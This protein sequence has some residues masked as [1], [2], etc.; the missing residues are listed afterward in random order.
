[1]QTVRKTMKLRVGGQTP[2]DFCNGDTTAEARSATVRSRSASG[3]LTP[4]RSSSVI[5]RSTESSPS[6]GCFQMSL[7]GA[8]S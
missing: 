3:N 5:T 1:M 8:A 4:N 7:N 2:A 6:S